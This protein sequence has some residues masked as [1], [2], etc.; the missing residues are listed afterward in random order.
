MPKVLAKLPQVILLIH[1][2]QVESSDS[3]IIVEMRNV[4]KDLQLQVL[5]AKKNGSF[6][7]STSSVDIFSYLLWVLFLRGEGFAI[8]TIINNT[9]Y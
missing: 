8:E 9:L 2:R 1:V 5:S 7:N 3:V 6:L 4:R